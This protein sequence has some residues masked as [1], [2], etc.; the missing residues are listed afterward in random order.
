MSPD[1]TILS[2][3]ERYELAGQAS[4]RERRNRP[5]GLLVLGLV[6]AAI[7]LITLGVGFLRD[8]SATADLRKHERQLAELVRLDA[9]LQALASADGPDDAD[10]LAPVPNLLTQL[11]DLA[12]DAGLGKPPTPQPRPDRERT[13]EGLQRIKI[14]YP[15]MRSS[16]P[17]VLLGWVRDATEQI[18]GL[19]VFSISLRPGATDWTMSVTFTRWER[20]GTS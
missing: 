8:R 20:K 7:G 5:R 17:A 16:D 14:T 10:E 2:E 3:D 6:V 9:Q 15:T 19:E 11:E 4:A 1:Q 13:A 18:P 12:I